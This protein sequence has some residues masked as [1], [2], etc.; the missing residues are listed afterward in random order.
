MFASYV[1][2]LAFGLALSAA[3][4]GFGWYLYR[5]SRRARPP[6]LLRSDVVGDIVTV[7]EMG[8]IAIGVAYLIDGVTR[9]LLS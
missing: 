6:L 9:A 1:T 5:A 3:A 8:L 7:C 4:V 2:E